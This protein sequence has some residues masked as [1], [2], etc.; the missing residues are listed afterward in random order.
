MLAEPTMV[1]Y[2]DDN[3]KSRR[4]LT[5][6]LRESGFEVITAS[7]PLE[8]LGVCKGI[9]FDLA[10]LDHQMPKMTGSQLAQE[11][12][13]LVPDIPVVLISGERVLPPAE[14]AFVDAHFG[15]GTTLD[16]LLNGLRMLMHPNLP[17]TRVSRST[18]PWAD[19]T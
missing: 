6:I 1:F 2:V 7:D 12:K 16:E 11:I 18:L 17:L 9:S 19:S 15:S 8:A 4:L 10:L 5:S 3:A 14:L 13:F